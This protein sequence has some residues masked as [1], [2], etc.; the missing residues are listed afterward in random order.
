MS[1]DLLQ[2]MV[3]PTCFVLAG[4]LGLRL[5]TPRTVA[6]CV[7]LV[8]GLHLAGLALAAEAGDVAGSPGTTLH[9]LSQVLFAGGFAALVGTSLTYPRGG[10]PPVLVWGATALAVLGPVTASLAGPTRKVYGE[11]SRGPFAEV[12]PEPLAR[13]GDLSLAALALVAVVG[14]AARYARSPLDVRPMMRWPLLGVVLVGLLA[15][16]GV[17]LGRAFPAAGSVAFLLAAPVL[18]LSLAL[19]PV[20]RRLL[21][22]TEETETL[23]ADLAAR[24]T[25]LEDSRRRLSTAAEAERRRIERDLHDGAQQEL[26]ALIAHVEVA[27]NEHPVPEL[28]RVATLARGAYETVRQVA[29]GIRPAALDDLGLAGAVRD[30]VDTF[31]VA[32]TL[33]VE[34]LQDARL[35]G[36]TEGAAFYFVSEALANVLK[37]SGADHVLVRL[38]AT[39]EALW[40]TVEDDGRGGVDPSGSGVRGLCDRVEAHGGR[41][42]IDSRP[43]RSRLVAMFPEAH[44]A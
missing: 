18:P 41:V 16:A 15:A 44:R 25:E 17:L 35:D 33:E 4:L 11:G 22:L 5:G 23:S 37:H 31:P 21:A 30:V 10:R 28:D 42:T 19:G 38:S 29:Q 12:L 6:V 1:A 26:L 27:R 14:F 13:A 2:A 7:V 39:G 3:V 20:R 9:V 8:G 24:V 34:G 43:G 40:V 32:T 36:T